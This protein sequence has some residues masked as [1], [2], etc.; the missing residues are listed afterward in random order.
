MCVP[1]PQNLDFGKPEAFI[2]HLVGVLSS[3]YCTYVRAI[4]DTPE[5]V[6]LLVHEEIIKTDLSDEVVAELF[7]GICKSI[8]PV[9]APDLLKEIM[10]VNA[11]FDDSLKIKEGMIRYVYSAG[12]FY[13][14]VAA[15]VFLALLQAYCSVYNC[16][17]TPKYSVRNA[18]RWG[19]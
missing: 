13:T 14:V 3:P 8:R 9:N 10:K 7:N 5:D 17:G 11:K 4:I 6:K 1:C 2:P 12:K 18:S 16:S 19:L 15:L